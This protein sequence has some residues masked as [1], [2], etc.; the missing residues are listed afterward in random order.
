[1]NTFG[2]R[3]KA[4]RQDRDLSVRELA[5]LLGKTGGYVSRI[6]TQS[7]IPSPDLIIQLAVALK[8]APTELLDLARSS[9]LEQTRA[10]VTE[11]HAEALRLYRKSR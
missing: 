9:V 11:R 8:V 6:E 5:A 1:V 7:E 4:L 2:Q 3:I 10:K